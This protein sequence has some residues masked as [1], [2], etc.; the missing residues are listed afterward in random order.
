M[1][2]KSGVKGLVFNIQRFSV[3]DGPGIRT[4]VFLKGCPLRCQ[5]CHNPE[6]MNPFPEITY[7]ESKCIKCYECIEVCPTGAISRSQS[8]ITIDREK[9]DECGKELKEGENVVSNRIILIAKNGIAFEIIVRDKDKVWNKGSICIGCA[10]E[11]F[12]DSKKQEG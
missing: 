9:C 7:H 12:K 8:G 1:V 6:S 11:L 2:K 10:K 3:H 5:W 4:T